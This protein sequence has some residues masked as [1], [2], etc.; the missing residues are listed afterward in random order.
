[1]NTINKQCSVIKLDDI[2]E[3]IKNIKENSK[4]IS[5]DEFDDM[6]ECIIP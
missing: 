4:T 5:I 2:D 1:M 6:Y 3:Q